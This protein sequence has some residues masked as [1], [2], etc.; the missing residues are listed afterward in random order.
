MDPA[1]QSM[2][3]KIVF[4]S[5]VLILLSKDLIDKQRF[6]DAFSRDK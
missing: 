3:R 1:F 6:A 5:N 2:K 4:D